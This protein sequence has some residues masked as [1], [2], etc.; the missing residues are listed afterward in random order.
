M[1]ERT[2]SY[3]GCRRPV[4][5]RSQSGLC[6]AHARQ[7]LRGK[8]LRPLRPRVNER[9]E[10]C[11][12]EGCTRPHDSGGW[13]QGHAR[14]ARRGETM[15]PIEQRAAR[16]KTLADVVSH[17]Y[18]RSKRDRNGC[19]IWQ[20]ATSHNGY[21]V[22]EFAGRQERTHR[23]M[24]EARDGPPLD[25]RL[26]ATHSC[27]NPRCC[28]PS[29]LKWATA[30]E[31][32]IEAVSRDRGPSSKLTA[33]Q[34]WSIAERLE[35]GERNVDLAREYG[36]TAATISGI[37]RG[38]TKRWLTGK[39]PPPQTGRRNRPRNMTDYELARWL[40]G[41]T[42]KTK[43]GCMVWGGRPQIGVRGRMIDPGRVVLDA[44]YGECPPDHRLRR[45]CKTRLCLNP[46]HLEW[47]LDA[48]V[49]RPPSA[50]APDADR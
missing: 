27:D 2:C 32:Q 20:G 9:P 6:E 23:L 39:E 15:R 33:A 10:T 48:R 34:A 21:G 36:V 5:A 40:L 31:N 28:E 11:S 42:R 14:Q 47:V 45:T 26:L 13:C 38:V 41:E 35:R 7:R 3:R 49:R 1:P 16:R 50:P 22:T 4:G 19:L 44:L 25:P 30:Q 37:R 46:D 29:H 24:L 12:F 43:D 17:I 8:K 18:E